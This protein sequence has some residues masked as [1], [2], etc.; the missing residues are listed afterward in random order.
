MNHSLITKTVLAAALGLALSAIPGPADAQRTVAERQA[1]R[2][3]RENR[4]AA[5]PADTLFPNATRESPTA[6]MTQRMA[7]RVQRLDDML[8]GPENAQEVVAAAQELIN[9]RNANAYVKSIAYV[10]MADAYEEMGDWD[11]SFASLERSLTE[12]GFS[13]DNHFQTM[14][15]LGQTLVIE[16]R[17]EEGLAWLA[18]FFEESRSERPEHLALMG[19]VYYQAERF[20]EAVE[21][22]NRAIAA[23][24]NPNPQWNQILMA[25]YAEMGQGDEAVRVA[26]ELMAADPDNKQLVMNLASAHLQEDD[27]EA[28]GR[29]LQDARSRGLFDSGQDYNHLASILLNTDGKEAEAA[30]VLQEGLDKGIVEGNFDA[31]FMLGQAYYFS[32]QYDRAIVAWTQAA[33]MAPDG[34]TALNLARVHYDE[35]NWQEARRYANEAISKGIGNEETARNLIRNVEIELRR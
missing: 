9:D 6:T 2:E 33:T 32:E 17:T 20:P 35:G 18:R 31:H 27:Y 10:R 15:R 13:N 22:I 3:A 7:P 19:N 23:S 12:N 24:D 25:S 14:L 26:T 30:Q 28:A 16:E 29:V 11:N 4:S 1:A 34:E 21:Y 5:S 8:E